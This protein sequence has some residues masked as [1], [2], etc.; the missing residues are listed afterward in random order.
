MFSYTRCNVFSATFPDFYC[1][2]FHLVKLGPIYIYIYIYIF[3]YNSIV[4]P[5][6]STTVPMGS[7][8]DN[9]DMWQRKH[10][11]QLRQQQLDSMA[12]QVR[13]GGTG[14]VLDH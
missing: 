3:R 2:L 12:I 4:D 5:P 7:A 11:D 1:A 8:S 10:Q 13:G 6:F 9:L 14:L